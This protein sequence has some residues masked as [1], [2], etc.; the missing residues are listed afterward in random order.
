MLEEQET[1]DLLAASPSI[2]KISGKFASKP[3]TVEDAAMQLRT[4]GNTLLLFVNADMLQVNL[5]YEMA[6]GESGWVKPEFT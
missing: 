6:G 3:V 1:D 5:L 2:V 4:S